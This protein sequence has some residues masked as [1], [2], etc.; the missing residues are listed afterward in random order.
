VLVRKVRYLERSECC[1]QRE[2][3][4]RAVDTGRRDGEWY[5][6]SRPGHVDGN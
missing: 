4:W 2:F 1:D 3:R 6:E 5:S